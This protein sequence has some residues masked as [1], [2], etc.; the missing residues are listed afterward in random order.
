MKQIFNY[1]VSVMNK[2]KY[3]NKFALISVFFISLIGGMFILMNTNVLNN[4]LQ[5]RTETLDY[6]MF[7]I[8]II[9]LII[10]VLP[11]YFFISLYLSIVDTVSVLE[12]S[13]TKMAN[14]NFTDRATVKTDDELGKLA[15]LLNKTSDNLGNLIKQVINSTEEISSGSKEVN[16]M[17]KQTTQG[18]EQVSRTITQMAT[19]SKEQ[20]NHVNNG[21]AD[22]TEINKTIINI[23]D[24]AGST[25]ELSQSTKT[26]ACKGRD[27]ATEAIAKINQIKSTSMEISETINELGQLSTKIEQIVD[28]IKNIAS[29]T[30][31][32]ALNAAIE[33]ARAGEHG[34]GFAVVAQEVKKLADQSGEASNKITGMIKEIQAKTNIAV[35]AMNGSIEQVNDGVTIVENTGNDLEEILEAANSASD[36]IYEITMEI[37]KLADNSNN[38][39][40][41][42]ENISAITEASA[43]ST[44]EI[45]SITAEQTANLEEINLNSQALAKIVGNLQNKII[46]FHV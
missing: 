36:K 8:I 31:L 19:G 17:V 44:K 26:N 10:L 5:T 7:V 29:Q 39:V 27:Q 41:I 15:L 35:I 38:V 11:F 32:L 33:A 30:N 25:V 34:K 37:E 46:V 4:I 42:M 21:L 14:G 1:G 45:S 13:L 3:S 40:K 22:I 43:A 9:S 23:F 16:T 24:A 2:L 20:T 28:L 12:K 18:S 6:G